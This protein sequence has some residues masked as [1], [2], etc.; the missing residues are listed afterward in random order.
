MNM[1]PYLILGYTDGIF[2]NRPSHAFI[3]ARGGQGT[4]VTEERGQVGW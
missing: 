4:T 3:A 2:K 1:I